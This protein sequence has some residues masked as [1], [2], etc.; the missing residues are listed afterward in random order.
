MGFLPEPEDGP[1]PPWPPPPVVALGPGGS[2]APAAAALRSSS[3]TL[4]MMWYTLNRV[5][6]V[7]THPTEASHLPQGAQ[8]R[9]PDHGKKQLLEQHWA[10]EAAAVNP[11]SRGWVMG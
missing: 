1:P 6:Q 8:I 2:S 5:L 4:S 3:R 9:E 11:S 10:R 7:T